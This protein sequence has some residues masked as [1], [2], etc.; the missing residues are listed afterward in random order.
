MTIL[1]RKC[2][3]SRAYTGFTLV[4]LLARNCQVTRCPTPSRARGVG[5]LYAVC[6]V[7][8]PGLTQPIS[9]SVTEKI[10]KCFLC[11]VLGVSISA[12]FDQR[13]DRQ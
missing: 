8:S 13:F 9:P 10:R 11:E 2:A 3:T 7:K 4:E 12:V 5:I 6:Y 1:R